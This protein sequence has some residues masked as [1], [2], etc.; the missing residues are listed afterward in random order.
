MQGLK[1]I[2][3]PFRVDFKDGQ[4]NCKIIGLHG[5]EC[6]AVENFKTNLSVLGIVVSDDGVPVNYTADCA[7]ISCREGY[8]L[9]VDGKGVAIKASAKE[10][11]LYAFCTLGQLLFNFGGVLPYCSIKD[12]PK[13]DYRGLLLDCGR[14]FFPKE[15]VFRFI[16]F[17]LLHK[18]N[19]LHWHLTEDQGW[20]ISIDRYPLLTE[21]GSR[22]SH[23]NFGCV[24]HGGYYTKADLKE[25]IAYANERNVQVIPEIDMPGHIQSAIACYPYLS[26][27]DRKL[28][29]ATHWGVK[30][31]VLCAGK[32]STYEFVFGVL[33]EIM[34]VFGGENTKYIHIGGDEVFLQ[35]WTMCEHCQAAI[36]REG[37]ADESELQAYFMRRVSDYVVSKGFVPIMWNGLSTDRYLNNHEVLQYWEDKE[38]GDE[39]VRGFAEKCGGYINNDSAYTY[40]DLPYGKISLKKS[41]GYVPLPDNFPQEKFLGAEIALWTEYVPNFKRACLRLL[42]RSCALSET[43]WNNGGGDYEE[44]ESRL[45]SVLKY[46]ELF[47][48]ESASMG[49]ANPCKLRGA[50]QRAWFGRR[51]LHWQ[52]LHNLL[53]DASVKR[54][55]IKKK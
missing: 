49:A 38:N 22:R 3:Y 43:M 9:N 15:D 11:L 53:D 7:G 52:G 41:Y 8:E 17:C 36:K 45:G 54:K 34:E 18:L 37:L 33:D 21:K 55:Y 46:L 27:F 28:K 25:I 50:C 14:Y 51:V 30:H 42:P 24:P 2:P 47:G 29:V 1:L 12:E 5:D 19:V 13:V 20:R 48:Y 6:F 32:E 23:T 40:V 35:R 26:C 31:D 39:K 44:F 10:G 16:D 4:L